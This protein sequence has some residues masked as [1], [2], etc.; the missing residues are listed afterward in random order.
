M[1]ALSFILCNLFSD[2]L[3]QKNKGGFSLTLKLIVV[4]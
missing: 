1:S 3:T 2:F 4:W